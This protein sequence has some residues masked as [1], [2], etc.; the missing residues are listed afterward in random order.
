MVNEK[1]AW[2]VCGMG[3]SLLISSAIIK[4]SILAYFGVG[5]IILSV[6]LYV[7]KEDDASQR[8]EVTK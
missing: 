1:W 3:I 5:A 6:V 4:S 8:N 2:F 7:S